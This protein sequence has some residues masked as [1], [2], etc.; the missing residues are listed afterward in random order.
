MREEW[1][2]VQDHLTL[3]ALSPDALGRGRVELR[4]EADWGS[5]FGWSQDVAGERP[6]D[7]RFLVD[8]EHASGALSAR[9]GLTDRVTA[10]ARMPLRWRGAGVLDGVIDAWHSITGLPDGGRDAFRTG[11]FRVEGRDEAGRPVRWTGR[12]GTGL[13]RAELSLAVSRPGPAWTLGA[14]AH[15]A[16]PTST[17]PFPGGGL[18]LGGQVLAARAL[19]GR[20]DVAL[21]LGATRFGATE[22]EGVRLSRLRPSGFLSLEWRPAP[23]VSLL[24]E[25]SASG[26][27]VEGLD[28]YPALQSYLRLGFV[29]DVGRRARAYG[30]F[31]ENVA[32]QDATTDFSVFAGLVIL[33]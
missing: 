4:L 2:L 21:G 9:Y 12:P 30:G 8:G 15:A 26:R 14:V 7:R 10:G 27:L 31:A 22:A 19:G 23:H 20:V 24:A 1:L 28:G 33:R 25:T 18:D 16:L 3:P 6:G 13:G 11:R 5:D 29:L 32:R 17:A